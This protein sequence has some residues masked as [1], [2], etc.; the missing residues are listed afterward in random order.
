MQAGRQRAQPLQAV[1]VQHSHAAGRIAYRAPAQEPQQQGKTPIAQL[2]DRRHLG[3]RAQARAQHHIGPFLQ[4]RA[5]QRRQLAGIAGAVRIQKRQPLPGGLAEAL[6]QRSP[7]TAVLGQVDDPH[8]VERTG[9]FP[10][11]VGRAVVDHQDLHLGDAR[12]AD[13]R[14]GGQAAGQR[15]ADRLLLV[16]RRDDD[17]E[18]VTAGGSVHTSCSSGARCPHCDVGCVLGMHARTA[19]MNLPARTITLFA[20]AQ[21]THPTRACSRWRPGGRRPGG[22][23]PR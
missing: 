1:A 17:R 11:P 19:G 18:F 4:S 8:A 9:D 7:I 12:L 22:S 14:Y 21:S 10:R 5:A 6:G 15:G 23:S 16:E 13:G 20:W 2:A 3:V